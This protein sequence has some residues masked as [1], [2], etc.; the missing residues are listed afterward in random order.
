VAD[1]VE[2]AYLVVAHRDPE[3]CRRLLRALVG[4]QVL[5]YV[6]V[7][8][9]VPLEEFLVGHPQITF[10]RRRLSVN[11]GGWSLVRAILRLLEVAH[12]KSA[13]SHFV[14][15]AGTD[16]PLRSAR[17][18]AR[19]LASSDP[20]NH[21]NFYP[22]LEGA[23]GLAN[24]RRYHFVD[25]TV[26]WGAWL[27]ARRPRPI[28]RAESFPGLVAGLNRALPQRRF[29]AGLIPFRGS[30]RWILERETAAF[31]LSRWRA[32][33][34]RA[35]R[36]YLR[37]T[38]GADEMLVQTLVLNSQFA[39]RCRLY[40][41]EAVHAMVSGQVPPWE[42]EVRPYEHYIDWDPLRE[43]PAILDLRDLERL[44]KSSKLFACKFTSERSRELLDRIDAELLADDGEP[45]GGA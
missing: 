38:W 27:A 2:I 28:E 4:E 43:D 18:I 10:L 16:Y 19:R 31:V 3:Q 35:L 5:V 22:L 7:D 29:P 14:Y 9:R 34:T 25:A 1:P 39:E 23:S 24:F 26:R 17:A 37:Y 12:A 33:A 41:A 13:A 21:L 8:A 30:S 44:R 6:H 32:S 36:R 11:R 42:D 40:D 20:E 15:L 45:D